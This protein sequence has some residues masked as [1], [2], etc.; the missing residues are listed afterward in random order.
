LNL[1]APNIVFVPAEFPILRAVEAAPAK[2]T[3]VAVV[4]NSVWVVDEPTIVGLAIV[5]VP[6]FE[7]PML[8]FVV[9]LAAPPVPR[10]TVLVVPVVV[11][12]V[13]KL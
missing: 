6:P 8:T 11:A 10:L 5:V 1:D 7:E 4:L 2:F 12:P 13:P 3:V 9:E